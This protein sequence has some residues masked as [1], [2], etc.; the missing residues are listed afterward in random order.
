MRST[1]CGMS[2]ADSDGSAATV[3]R[4]VLRR[5]TSRARSTTDDEVGQHGVDH[6]HQ[7]LARLRERDRAR[8][9]V[10]ELHAQ[11]LLEVA[12]LRRQRR[13]RGVQRVRRPG[14]AAETADGHEGAELAEVDIHINSR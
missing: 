10:E 12:D 9:A 5:A 1:T 14:E 8:A 6:G 3:T 2:V 4:P 13:L 11:R 7:V